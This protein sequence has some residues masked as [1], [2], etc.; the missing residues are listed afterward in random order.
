MI[1]V[2]KLC[3]NYGP[4]EAV[5]DVTFEVTKGEVIGFVG[6]NGA[7]KTTTMKILT[8]Y[9]PATSGRA[10][11]AGFDVAT[12][13][14]EVRRRIGYLPEDNPLYTDMEV[15][16]YLG[17]V[18]EIRGLRRRERKQSLERMIEVCSLQGVVRKTIRELSRGYRQRVGLAQAMIHDPDILILDEPTS[19]LD[20]SQ[21]IEIRELIKR[22]GQEKTVI[23]SSHILPE[24]ALTCSRV[25]VIHRGGL[26]ANGTPKELQARAKGSGQVRMRVRGPKDALEAGLHELP[27]VKHSEVTHGGADG[28]WLCN[29]TP[30]G[31]KD[32]SEKLFRWVVKKDWSVAELSR[33]S[34]SLEDVF[35]EF[36]TKQT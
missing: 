10:S 8:C 27:Y 12:H 16:A 4:T 13:S 2:E 6:P 36:T 21:I 34:A 26:V 15:R 18:G 9:I 30:D 25:I 22:I 19:G 7:G 32:I 35:L 23:L 11:V 29:I 5:V 14:L 1:N 33:E 31:K 24:V 17:Y 28:L 20:P 3:K